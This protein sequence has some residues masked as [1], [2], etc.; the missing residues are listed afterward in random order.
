MVT[1]ALPLVSI[2]TPSYNQGQFIEETVCSV[3]AQ[4]YPKFEHLV[5]DGGSTDDTLA[6]LKKYEGAYQMRWISEADEGQAD[7]IQKGFNLCQG[8]IIC[9]LNS[10]DIY[11]SPQILSRVVS[12]FNSYPDVHVV[13]GGGVELSSDGQWTR[14][15]EIRP[16][17]INYHRLRWADHV[18]QPATFF[19]RELLLRVK[20]DTSL[21]YAFDWDLFLQMARD[22]NFLAVNEPWAGYRM[23]GE[24]KT[25]AGGSKRALELMEIISR[26]VGK[27]SYQYVAVTGYYLL[28]RLSEVLPNRWQ[29]RLKQIIRTFSTYVQ[30]LTFHRI[31]SV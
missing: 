17:Y 22:C 5:I 13:T 2:I 28:L 9:W 12:L 20:L 23:W 8:D 19:R 7:A 27:L 6:V 21:H 4:D 11:L 24:N 14:Q 10:D 18:L 15:I 30:V 31:T 25:G 1:P 3:M 26:Y 29:N 16:E